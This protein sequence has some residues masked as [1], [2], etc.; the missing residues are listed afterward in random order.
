MVTFPTPAPGIAGI[1][2]AV[3]RVGPPGDRRPWLV[4]V[5]FVLIVVIVLADLLTPPSIRFTPFLAAAPAVT[6]SFAGART[7]AGVGALAVAS[8]IATDHAEAPAHLNETVATIA[9]LA[10]SVFVALFARLR[11]HYGRRYDQARSLA[12]T[13]QNAV[14]RPLPLRLGRIEIASVYLAAEA[15]AVIGGDLYAAARTAT[16][17]RLMIGD[18]RGKGLGAIGE[19]ALVMG[20]FHAAAHQTPSLD[21]LVS[22]LD[23]ALAAAPDHADTP[24]AGHGEEFVTALL[25]DVPDRAGPIGV[26]SCGHP[27]PV[28]VRHGRPFVPPLP[29]AAP[30]LGLGL[31][32]AHVRTGSIPWMPGDIVLLCTD[33]VLEA[34][35]GSG[36]FYP[37]TE[38]IRSWPGG[39]PRSLVAYL[40]TDLLRHTGGGALNDDAALVAFRRV[41]HAARTIPE[42]RQAVRPSAGR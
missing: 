5:P 26:A 23:G 3:R 18:V 29:D 4:A 39:D 42:P 7:T 24:R 22:T 25:L 8:Q 38:R 40:R 13:A 10:V 6:A 37:L 28:V 35:D 34:R 9:L 32:S 17:T 19:A 16:G 27:P 14:L 33:G 15:E 36:R 2:S 30:P 12:L 21:G 41:P 20:A 31:A 1:T 11:E